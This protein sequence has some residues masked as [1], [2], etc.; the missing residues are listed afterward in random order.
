MNVERFVVSFACFVL[1]LIEIS[2][3]SENDIWKDLPNI[4]EVLLVYNMK[5]LKKDDNYIF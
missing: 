1:S 5:G 3:V 4:F 2:P